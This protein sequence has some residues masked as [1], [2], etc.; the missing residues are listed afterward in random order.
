[1]KETI[2]KLMTSLLIL[3]ISFFVFLN[4]SDMHDVDAAEDH[5]EKWTPSFEFSPIVPF[6]FDSQYVYFKALVADI[7]AYDLDKIYVIEDAYD[8]Y[9]LSKKS[10]EED[11]AI[12]LSL[13]YVLGND[14]DYYDAV[15][16]NPDYRFKPIG[17]TSPFNGTFDGQ[18]F[19]ISN[20]YFDS[21]LEEDV[22]HQSYANLT[23]FSMFSKTAPDAVIT[24]FGLINPIIIQPLSFGSMRHVAPLV[25]HHE[26]LISHVYIKD[27][28]SRNSGYMVEGDFHLS[29]L[30]SINDGIIHDAYIVTEQIR[31]LQS[32]YVSSV[33]TLV[34]SNQG[35]LDRVYYDQIVYK[36]K[37]YD[38]TWGLGIDTL[39][40]QNHALFSEGW[41][42]KDSY[43]GIEENTAYHPQLLLDHAYPI[44]K[45]LSYQDGFFHLEKP[46]DLLY[47][48][49]VL[50]YSGYFRQ[51]TYQ[52]THDL[53]MKAIARDAY[54]AAPVGF[55]GVLQSG[56]LDE[57][58]T[59]FD[60]TLMQGGSIHHY[61]IMHLSI[62][63]PTKMGYFDG[64]GLF[65]ML[66]GTVKDLNFVDASIANQVDLYQTYVDDISIGVISAKI[67]KGM[68]DNVH[69]HQ[70]SSINTFFESPLSLYVGSVSGEASGSFQRIT[71]SGD[72]ESYAQ[73]GKIGQSF[74]MGGLFG[75]GHALALEEVHVRTS[76]NG[77]ENKDVSSHHYLGGM[78]GKTSLIYGN[79]L[80]FDGVMTSRQSYIKAEK[81][82]LGG[83]FGYLLSEEER[84]E[85]VLV[86]G[87]IQFED[88]YIQEVSISGLFQ[89]YGEG[90]GVYQN[91]SFE[92]SMTLDQPL[93]NLSETELNESSLMLTYGI[94]TR[95]MDATIEGLFI[96]SSGS[97][98][99]GMIDQFS[100][101][102]IIHEGFSHQVKQS[103]SK[104]DLVFQ[105]I[106]PLTKEHVK[107]STN[108]LGHDVSMKGVRHEG[109]L[110]IL[111]S[112]HDRISL[113]GSL[114]VMGL[115]ETL[116]SG[117]EASDL[118]NQGQT[119]V[120][121]SSIEP[122]N[123]DVFVSG[124]GLDI[125]AP[126]LPLLDPKSIEV[127]Q[128]IGVLDHA[129][130]DHDIHVSLDTYG[131]T[132]LSGGV[133]YLNNIMTHS[134]NFGDI[135]LKNDARSES[136]MEASGIATRLLS[137]EARILNS[138]NEG[139]I[140]SQSYTPLGYN[141]ASGIS[142]RNDLNQAHQVIDQAHQAHL[143]KIMF[144][145]NYGDIYAYNPITEDSTHGFSITTESK[146]KAGG[147]FGL[148]LLSLI[149]NMN[150]GDVYAPYVAGGLQAFLYLNHFGQVAPGEIYVSNSIQYG[151]V[152]QITSY[153]ASFD[154]FE[155]LDGTPQRSN[156]HGFGAI[157]GK[158]HNGL[159]TWAFAGTTNPYHMENYYFG[160][161]LNIDASIHM[162]GLA[163]D[164]TGSSGF[165]NA[166]EANAFLAQM[167]KYMATT[168]P[169]DQSAPP[170]TAFEVYWWFVSRLVG[171]QIK[172][173]DTTSS[174][175][176]MFSEAFAFRKRMPIY[177]GTDQYIHAYI[178]YVPKGKANPEMMN[179]LEQKHN[180]SLDG[181]YALSSSSGTK[182]GIFM[183]YHMDFN[184]FHDY[185]SIP[186]DASWYGA[187]DLVDSPH[188]I[189]FHTLR[190]MDSSLATTIY[191][192]KLIQGTDTEGPL[193]GGLTL[194]KPVIDEARGLLT[195]YL[196]SNAAL[197]N[198]HTP[199]LMTVS[200]FVE[201]QSG[202]EGV[203]EV[204][205]ISAT[206][207]VTYKAV[208]T[209]QKTI[210]GHM[211][212][213]GPYDVSGRYHLTE[214]SPYD[215]YTEFGGSTYKKQQAVYR[216]TITSSSDVLSGVFKHQ[217][218]VYT[219]LWLF[220]YWSATG[221]LVTPSLDLGAG[222]G[223]Y[224]QIILSG[225][226]NPVYEYVGPSSLSVTYVNS[227]YIDNV[228]VFPDTSDMSF[229]PLLEE[230]SYDMSSEA[231]FYH[232]GIA[233]FEQATIPRSYGIY[234]AMYDSEGTFI[235]S[236]DL[237]YGSIRVYSKSYDP[238]IPITYRDYDIRI[239]R[240]APESVSNLSE[241]LLNGLNGLPEVFDLMDVTATLPMQYQPLK[242]H[243]R[244][245]ITYQTFDMADL[246]DV[247]DR[248]V[249]YDDMDEPV[250][251]AL[252]DIT[253]GM[254]H[255]DNPFNNLT[256]SFGTGVLK[257]DVLLDDRLSEGTY[258]LSL[259]LLSLQTYDITFIIEPSDQ[260]RV[261]S[262]GY[263]R[264]THL[265]EDS[266]LESYIP[267]GIYFDMLHPET[268]MVDFR[269]LGE[270]IDIKED[271]LT[272]IKPFYLD[273]ITISP[274][275][276]IKA[277]DL[278]ITS[279]SD[280][281]YQYDIIYTIE[282]E[283]LT[284]STFTHRLIEKD[285]SMGISKLYH[286]GKSLDLNVSPYA[287]SY[288]DAPTMRIEYDLDDLYLKGDHVM[289][290]ELE[291]DLLLGEEVIEHVDYFKDQ[292][293]GIGYEISLNAL[294]PQGFYDIYMTFEQSITL[295][296][297][298]FVWSR[299]FEGAQF[300]KIQNHESRLKNIQ[301]ISDE[302]YEGFQVIMDES[303]IDEETY[304]YYIEH[305]EARDYHV[306][307]T[308]G[309]VYKDLTLYNQYYIVG[310]VNKT[311]I[312]YFEPV[313][314]IPD[315]AMIKRV[316]NHET[317][318]PDAQSDILSTDFS[319]VADGFYFVLYRIY[320]EDFDMITRPD[321]FTDYYI[322]VHDAS[323]NV[324]LDIEIN[325]TMDIPL[326]AL[327]V[328]VSI[329]QE[330]TI[331]LCDM[332]INQSSMSLFSA[333]DMV[334]S[335]YVHASFQT[336][337]Y[338]FYAMRV[339][340][341]EGYTYEI[342][343]ENV[344]LEEGKIY[345]ASSI[346][347]R[348]YRVQITISSTMIEDIW[349]IYEQDGFLS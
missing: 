311:M 182:E 308:V 125:E 112:S 333:Y 157:I 23:Y 325:D 319:V 213:I 142:V 141:H 126:I 226:L 237:H 270:I 255:A 69:I 136:Y 36:E 243:R 301:F 113:K 214:S 220:R 250:D 32:R 179:E 235:D 90:V 260:A 183:P 307:P 5:L 194:S 284:L 247:S 137:K 321:G 85:N 163:P 29:G 50:T 335:R 1:M 294:I 9:M 119:E 154:L 263:Q 41:F 89:A 99:L 276:Q 167:V 304:A 185:Q 254:V 221:V 196:P 115:F 149:N 195:Y 40:F 242:K 120:I 206:N 46:T 83:L 278:I 193:S 271:M 297:Y 266:Y 98:D 309:I 131:H 306:L 251:V 110:D 298:D 340:L 245:D 198:G 38:D 21:I 313:F 197:L 87:T 346:I 187:L 44:L 73:N 56:I 312:N 11:Q 65:S 318:D 58:H 60:H 31:A 288:Q 148:G 174:E 146:S 248:L 150:Y 268:S 200:R 208:G 2:K 81:T 253:Y 292:L 274:F 122:L 76:L 139:D 223:A 6:S 127:D 22:Y 215:T 189:M 57:S 48:Q 327:Y 28:R 275:S 67:H 59:L 227:G 39:S 100:T 259:E 281:R 258:T 105:T 42:Y 229:I 101:N 15:L 27:T 330:E 204:P 30:V 140:V 123:Y 240:T 343:V 35:T 180:M 249:L 107:I 347:P 269:N 299:T 54:Q 156:V 181:I 322:A 168:H 212:E 166:E 92:G 159:S 138:I 134:I 37:H 132:L 3:G 246:Y 72:I 8:L 305:Q 283:N 130:N 18:G 186:Y 147:L 202:L 279:L 345:L 344:L 66:F 205:E 80:L 334:Q 52:V 315:H 207:E 161:L 209:H 230:G 155:I 303:Y 86:E 192:L 295:W 108:I 190:Q 152:R 95:Q 109:D 348:R 323:Q 184:R 13:H 4:V 61:V 191:D 170:F 7:H 231:S 257:I 300:E 273:A 341:P 201:A 256:G 211:V 241:L 217:P 93:R 293:D 171:T 106:H 302:I 34:Y 82:Y 63:K 338:G 25:G 264:E 47:M 310:T 199:S 238:M 75:Y 118:L 165:S 188:Y 45:G 178:E 49:K 96:S 88:I 114:Y 339:I 14:I 234:E 84:L 97:F 177:S 331:A 233:S 128:T 143:A 272:N 62:Q 285:V 314:D 158:I 324:R 164:A 173:L 336:T 144:T 329:C 68:I 239:I 332:S 24:H 320:A 145:M 316:T 102:L 261:L 71:S 225:Y 116:S 79:K 16:S 78:V 20:L 280:Q 218:H 153:D 203:R 64:Y 262:I 228:S 337:S 74:Y 342:R 151:K 349:G 91:L 129:I 111:L 222:Y 290:L 244:L 43:L 291:T 51:A 117:H 70:E 55:S 296:G 265:I 124:L 286:N 19:E 104:G 289:T 10:S 216:E 169:N 232:G 103:Y 210:D 236:V 175:T 267:Q 77:F 252:Y 317:I 326:E 133:I 94:Q 160:Y 135:T 172:Y 219:D 277:I 53:D 12:Y 224:K 17:F 287:I 26:G 176:G 33:N 121:Q 162:F 328:E 282:S